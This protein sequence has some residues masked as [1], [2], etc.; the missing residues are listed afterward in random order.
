MRL[1][2]HQQPAVTVSSDSRHQD[3]QPVTEKEVMSRSYNQQM[4]KQMGWD[5]PF[6]V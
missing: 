5:R 3:E 4:A 2:S 1:R 6:E